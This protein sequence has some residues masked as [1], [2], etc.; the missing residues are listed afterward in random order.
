M[1]D[2]LDQ[3]RERSTEPTKR[4]EMDLPWVKKLAEDNLRLIEALELAMY[5][6]EG[7]ATWE[8]LC[9]KVEAVLKGE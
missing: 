7:D 9:L 2:V 8:G 4:M 3:M 5:Y 6:V 1:K